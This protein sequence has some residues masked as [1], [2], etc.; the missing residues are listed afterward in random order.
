MSS[1]IWIA[2]AAK[3]FS[4]SLAPSSF[5]NRGT[6]TDERR[7]AKRIFLEYGFRFGA[8]VRC[9]HE[10]TNP[11]LRISNKPGPRNTGKTQ[12]SQS[13]LTL[14]NKCAVESDLGT[15]KGKRLVICYLQG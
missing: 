5:I 6:N 9:K 13:E 11:L 12:L 8:W 7:Q 10:K 1:R 15:V 14:G 4:L 3:G 2:S